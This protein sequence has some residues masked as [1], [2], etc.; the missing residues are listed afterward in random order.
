MRF[1]RAEKRDIYQTLYGFITVIIA[2][3]LATLFP[4]KNCT[5]EDQVT[6]LRLETLAR[7]GNR[8]AIHYQQ[9]RESVIICAA[10]RE[11]LIKR[12]KEQENIVPKKKLSPTDWVK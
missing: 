10:K 1:K 6:D 9:Q 5:C 3:G 7:Q 2:V 12:L 11:E 4:Q 8:Q